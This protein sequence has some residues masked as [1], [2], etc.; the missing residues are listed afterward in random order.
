MVN[1]ILARRVNHIV[2]KGDSPAWPKGSKSRGFSKKFHG[3]NMKDYAWFIFDITY[4]GDP[5]LKV[6]K[7]IK[8]E[9][10]YIAELR[11]KYLSKNQIDVNESEIQRLAISSTKDEIRQLI[12]HLHING[13]S[14]RKIAKLLSISEGKVRYVLRQD[15]GA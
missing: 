14:N 11:N 3:K 13:L 15:I 7:N 8:V 9:K 5:I 1:T 12:L 6:I 4:N 10:A 2:A